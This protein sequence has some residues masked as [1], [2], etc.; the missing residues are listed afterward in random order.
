MSVVHGWKIII[1][2]ISRLL[3]LCGSKTCSCNPTKD[4][5]LKFNYLKNIKNLDETFNNNS[6]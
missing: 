4:I 6:R 5:F 3:P 1:D 2:Y